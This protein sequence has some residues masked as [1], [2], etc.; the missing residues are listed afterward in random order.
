[1]CYADGTLSTEKL[2]L[3]RSYFQSL[4]VTLR[5]STHEER[6]YLMYTANS[7]NY[8]NKPVDEKKISERGAEKK[9]KFLLP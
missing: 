4:I 7:D 9:S 3:L 8:L 5:Y 6:G 2:F 1:M